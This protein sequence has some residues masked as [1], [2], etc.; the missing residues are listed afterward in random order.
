LEAMKIKGIIRTGDEST[1]FLSSSNI[2]TK[3][4]D[5]ISSDGKVL[6]HVQIS[7]SHNDGVSVAEDLFTRVVELGDGYIEITEY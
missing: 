3:S 4:S 7:E 1:A 2:I 5:N 6:Q